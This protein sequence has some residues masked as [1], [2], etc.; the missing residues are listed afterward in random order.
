MYSYKEMIENFSCNKHIAKKV[1]KSHFSGRQH[2]VK[3]FKMGT[4]CRE[5]KTNE[6]SRKRHNEQ[7]LSKNCRLQKLN[8]E[9]RNWK[10]VLAKEVSF[11]LENVFRIRFYLHGKLY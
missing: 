3:N 8:G 2:R 7:P 10:S 5:W 6:L 9:L 11:P 4:L 1:Q